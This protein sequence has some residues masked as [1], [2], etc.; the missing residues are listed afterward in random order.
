MKAFA[1]NSQ[2]AIAIARLIVTVLVAVAATFGWS[3]DGE[4]WFNIVISVFALILFAY[5]WWKN[6][7]IT[8]AA[9]EAQQVINVLKDDND[10]KFALVINDEVQDMGKEGTE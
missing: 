7:N 10:L 9:Q 1:F 5:S 8:N 4:L 3:L 2:S 6:N